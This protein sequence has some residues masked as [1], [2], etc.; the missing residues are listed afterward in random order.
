MLQAND[1]ATLANIDGPDKGAALTKMHISKQRGA[2]QLRVCWLWAPV[3]PGRTRL[4]SLGRS[5]ESGVSKDGYG[6][7]P[8]LRGSLRSRLRTTSEIASQTLRM[9]EHRTNLMSLYPVFALQAVDGRGDIR[10]QGAEA[11]LAHG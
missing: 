10:R 4:R 11:F 9:T 3:I 8:I 5:R 1:A 6:P 2:A 7:W